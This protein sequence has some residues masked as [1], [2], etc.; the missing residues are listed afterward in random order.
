MGRVIVV[1][2]EKGGVGKT[3]IAA[4]IAAMAAAAGHDVLLVDADPHQQSA[5]KWAARRA[6]AHPEAVAVRCVS[7]TGRGVQRQLED[8]AS[9]YAV[10]VV[11]TGAEDSPELR[12]AALVADV[13]VVP[14][15]ADNLDLWT[16]PTM[17][18]LY[19]RAKALNPKLRVVMVVNRIPYQLADT[20]PA[21]VAA[22]M[23]DNV[24]ALPCKRL[25]GLVGRTAYGRATG[26]G[27]GVAEMPRRD[28]KAV[29]ELAKLGEELKL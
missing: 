9:R 21:D 28:L 11:D 5:A 10:V 6:E 8:L 26:E 18:T 1:G 27:L 4:N 7:V 19:D 17:E 15:Q 14:L 2:N 12:A 25:V 13:L 20:A 3:T 16:L 29:S 22:W 24:P 23:R